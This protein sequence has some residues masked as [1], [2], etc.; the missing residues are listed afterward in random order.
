MKTGD[1]S[2][3]KQNIK[4]AQDTILRYLHKGIYVNISVSYVKR[5][6]L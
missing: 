1:N 3:K 4:K 6:R 2:E 5:W